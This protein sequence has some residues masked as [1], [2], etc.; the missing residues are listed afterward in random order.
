MTHARK[1]IFVLGMHRSGTSV[2]TG[3][4]SQF[5]VDPGTDLLPAN[6]SNPKGYFESK[7]VVE[8]NNGILQAVGSAWD[9]IQPIAEDAWDAPE[10]EPFRRQALEVLLDSASGNDQG[11]RII[12]DPRLSRTLPVWRQAIVDSGIDPAFIISLRDPAAVAISEQ[13]MKGLPFLKSLLLYIDYGLRAEFNTRGHRRSVVVY[14]DLVRYWQGE[15]IKLDLSLDLSLELRSPGWLRRRAGGFVSDD[16]NRSS[17]EARREEF[18]ACGVIARLAADVR[19]AL[20]A[21]DAPRLDALRADVATCL[22]WSSPWQ[23]VLEHLQGVE[24]R[25]FA[26]DLGRRYGG[27]KVQ[28]S[29]SWSADADADCGAMPPVLQRWSFARGPQQMRVPIPAGTLIA[30]L[31]IQLLDRAAV[32]HLGALA[33][34]A[35]GDGGQSCQWPLPGTT[36]AARAANAVVLAEASAKLPAL[37]LLLLDGKAWVE[38]SSPSGRALEI[39]SGG[40]LIIGMEVFDASAALPVLAQRVAKVA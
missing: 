20:I 37:R 4:L 11:L 26:A 35:D 23:P 18:D 32:V 17:I 29:V 16:L 12:K 22:H 14:E 1:C 3:L 39:P 7:R 15:L 38:V 25:Y 6:E 2:L 33:L 24:R 21:N 36:L 28:T 9:S 30:R 31:R 8:I 27:L 19:E 34:E 5:G 40:T 13:K 10:L